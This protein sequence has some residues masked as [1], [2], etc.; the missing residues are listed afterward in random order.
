ML[1]NLRNALMTG[2]RLPYDAEVEYLE[3]SGTQWINTGYYPNNNTKL[4]YRCFS[5]SSGTACGCMNGIGWKPSF[6]LVF[7]TGV[8]PRWG[9]NANTSY[10]P[11]TWANVDI[12]VEQDKDCYLNGQLVRSYTDTQFQMQYPLIVFDRSEL[13]NNHD[14]YEGKVYYLKIFENGVL[15]RD[16]IPVR[17]GSGSSAV[18]YLYDRVSGKLFGNAGTG[19]FVLGP[20]VVPVEYIESHGTEYIDTGVYG[21]Q[22]L[23]TTF[24]YQLEYSGTAPVAMGLFGCYTSGMKYYLY[25]SG[26]APSQFQVGMGD[27]YINTIPVDDVRHSI[28]FNN[29]TVSIDGNVVA[30]FNPYGAQTAY[31]LLLF[32]L[33]NI[34]GG[35]YSMTPMR[36]WRVQMWDNGTPVRDYVPVRVGT[37]ATSWE[38][39]MMDVLIRRIYRNQG[40]GAFGYGNDL[41]YP[42]PAE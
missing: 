31:T 30:T 5:A 3:S 21:S 33:H 6:S 24:D 11:F 23:R 17:V 36:K 40:T 2:K 26:V 39:A 9:T 14:P 4:Q 20:D 25:C 13:N 8:S 32:A 10:T 35:L 1:I 28:E 42:I 38:G 34:S 41:K 18:G 22:N 29:G 7:Y 15:V 27:S 12:T 37:D 16:Y 19:D